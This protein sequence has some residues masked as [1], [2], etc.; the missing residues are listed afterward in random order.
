MLYPQSQSILCQFIDFI[1]EVRVNN[2]LTLLN[3]AFAQIQVCIDYEHGFFEAKI[4]KKVIKII[5]LDKNDAE[6]D[7]PSFL[8]RNNETINYFWKET[9]V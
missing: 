9:S 4:K 6:E 8:S 2:N 1:I 3:Q 7:N 5:L